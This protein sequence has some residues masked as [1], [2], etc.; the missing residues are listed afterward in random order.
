MC[1]STYRK[2]FLSWKSVVVLAQI[3]KKQYFFTACL[4]AGLFCASLTNAQVTEDVS[5]G[6]GMM[7]ENKKW[8]TSGSA[9]ASMFQMAILELGNEQS[10][11]TLR[12]S[13]F[14]NT[15]FHLNYHAS[16]NVRIF[17]GLNIKNL[18]LIQR[19]DTS[20]NKYRA[21]TIGAPL[22]LKI[23][24]KKE[25]FLI[26]GGVDFPFNY[27]EKHWNKGDKKNKDKGNEWFSNKVN[28]VLTYGFLG[29]RFQN[30]LTAKI[31]YY[32]T[33]FWSDSYQPGNRSNIFMLTLG[34]DIGKSNRPGIKVAPKKKSNNV[35]P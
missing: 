34:F 14:F 2:G 27:K 17:S 25:F 13:L 20:I 24:D 11:S 28:P 1:K 6:Y 23:G 26:G 9:D 33:N 30:S 32:P 15:G 12:Y 22:G 21:Y 7:E 4:L 35:T 18:G 10:F 29:Y 3:M 31:Y 8:S 5:G 16:K 19:D